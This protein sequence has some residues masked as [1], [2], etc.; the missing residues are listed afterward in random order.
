MSLDD[1]REGGTKDHHTDR[2]LG[3]QPK[4]QAEPECR[5]WRRTGTNPRETSPAD[6][7]CPSCLLQRA[8][9]QIVSLLPE[10]VPS[11]IDELL[12][13]LEHQSEHVAD[14]I[15]I[16]WVERRKAA[17]RA[18]GQAAKAVAP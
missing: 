2:E 7:L 16:D 15:E 1:L 11:E 10:D 3:E 4:C 8:W 9:D 18:V 12:S 5:T 13:V 14:L 17:R 6:G